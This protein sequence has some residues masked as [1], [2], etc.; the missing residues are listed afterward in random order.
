M[1]AID[2][3]INLLFQIK[4]YPAAYLGKK[5]IT[6]LRSFIDGYRYALKT[7]NI[8]C[9]ICFLEFTTEWLEE[10]YHVKTTEG[11][12]SFLLK[13]TKDE[14]TAFDLFFEELEQFLKESNIEVPEIK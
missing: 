10:K 2:K 14:T 7:E 9:D 8:Q 3:A 1:E 11:W 12:Q 5:S 6:L 4:R 13:Q